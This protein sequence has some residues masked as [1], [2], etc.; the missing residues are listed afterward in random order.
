MFVH[1]TL[2]HGVELAAG[3]EAFHGGHA[4]SIGLHRKHH[5]GLHRVAIEV[6]GGIDE[7]TAPLVAEAGAT[8]FVAGNAIF[9][10]AQPAQALASL[11][12]AI[13]G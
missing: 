2:L 3:G 6:D 12:T 7:E 11:R 13:A 5:A 9:R 4:A 8:V 1:E 10:A